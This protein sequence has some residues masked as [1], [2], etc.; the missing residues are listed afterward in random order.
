MPPFTGKGVNLAMQDALELADALTGGEHA[1]V[2]SA[3]RAYESGML[4]RMEKEI[5]LVL[6][7]QDI[8]VSPIAPQGVIELFEARLRGEG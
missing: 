6:H 5:R 4:A 7:D 1:D 8:F 2:A 3:L